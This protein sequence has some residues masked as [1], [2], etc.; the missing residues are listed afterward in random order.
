MT[1]TP[2]LCHG[3]GGWCG[4]NCNCCPPNPCYTSWTYIY[5]CGTDTGSWDGPP[6]NAGCDCANITISPIGNSPFRAPALSVDFP[7]F[8]YPKILEE[9]GYVFGLEE[10]PNISSGYVFALDTQ[11]CSIPCE[12]VTVTLSFTGC[13][14][15]GSD[16]S[17]DAVGSG[18]VSISCDSS[19]VCGPFSCSVNGS[20]S[21]YVSN[22]DPISVS[23]VP[24]VESC[25][26]CCLVSSKGN[27]LSTHFA[28][29]Y[30]HRNVTTGIQKHYINKQAILN[31]ISEKVRSKRNS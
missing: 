16:F 5:L 11:S 30:K 10:I 12:T 1:C 24:T 8:E 18:T 23:I 9:K 19:S 15:Y 3:T 14:M 22:C 17:F 29:A 4:C 21:A 28:L 7:E 2:P 26:G 13:C 20:S 25:C 6:P 27:L 31:R